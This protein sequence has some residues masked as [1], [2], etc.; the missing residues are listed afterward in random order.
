MKKQHLHLCVYR[1]ETCGGPVVAGS[2][3]IRE[4]EIT[5][6]IDIRQVGTVCLSC[7]HGQEKN[8]AVALNLPPVE[9]DLSFRG[10]SG[11][12]PAGET[13]GQAAESTGTSGY[14]LKVA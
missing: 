5:K 4:T 10:I 6:E 3:G 14:S 9:W 7:G 8:E 1:C 13:G 12:E 11:Q 2:L